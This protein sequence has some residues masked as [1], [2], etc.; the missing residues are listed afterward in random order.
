MEE[1]SESKELLKK[2]ENR[3]MELERDLVLLEDSKEKLEKDLM[4]RKLYKEDLLKKINGKNKGLLERKGSIIKPIKFIKILFE[5]YRIKKE[6]GCLDKIRINLNEIIQIL[7]FNLN[8]KKEEIKD[9]KEKI[10]KN[11]EEISY[12]NTQISNGFELFEGKWFQKEEVHKLKEAKIGITNNFS[13]IS[14]FDFEHFI[15]RLLNEMGYKTQVTKKTGD[16]GV[17]IIA[18]KEGK[19][20]VV[21]CKRNGEKNLIGNRQIQQLLGSMPYFK[22]NHSLFVTTS[23]YTKQAIQQTKNAPIELWNKETLHRLVEKYFLKLDVHEVLD[24][25]EYEK[26]KEKEKLEEK[27]QELEEKKEREAKKR[28]CPR[29]NGLKMK[30]RKYCS[31][32]KKEIR[33][34][35]RI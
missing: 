28:E 33:M 10:D 22:A 26:R 32:C 1:Y 35:G 15:A 6:L 24:A 13:N 8:K 30:N 21:Q 12:T 5:R 14:P 11:R 3:K 9:I 18:E 2:L 23:F 7:E 25:I 19:R 4:E 20:T 17:D 34:E 29:C 27:R 31:K 16:Y